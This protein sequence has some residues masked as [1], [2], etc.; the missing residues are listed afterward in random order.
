MS[1]TNA[2]NFFSLILYQLNLCDFQDSFLKLWNINPELEN[3]KK[4]H[5]H[6]SHVY[7]EKEN[8]LDILKA[9][10]NIFHKNRNFSGIDSKISKL[11]QIKKKMLKTDYSR[12][13]LLYSFAKANVEKMFYDYAQ[14]V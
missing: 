2:T 9:G 14:N 4:F 6:F 10:I 11:F 1:V 5:E 8:I 12:L 13:S 7:L 3:E